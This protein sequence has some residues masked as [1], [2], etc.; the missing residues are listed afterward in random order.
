[1]NRSL[2][3]DS[4]MELDDLSIAWFCL[5]DEGLQTLLAGKRLRAR[6]PQP[7]LA[8]SEVL[9]MEADNGS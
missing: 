4:A 6:G 8:D 1:M 9:T 7:T 3:G 5:I 2:R